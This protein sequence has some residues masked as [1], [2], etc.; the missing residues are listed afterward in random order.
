MATYAIIDPLFK[1]VYV[2]RRFHWDARQSGDDLL[3]EWT[4]SMELWRR[5]TGAR[6]AIKLP[7]LMLGCLW[8]CSF[9]PCRAEPKTL[10]SATHSL[11]SSPSDSSKHSSSLS[12]PAQQTWD[13]ALEKAFS[14]E[15]YRWRK[16]MN[17]QEA[18]A[19][20][21][22]LDKLFFDMRTEIKSLGR[23]LKD[24]MNRLS[25]WLN[26]WFKH[27][28]KSSY[29][30]NP[31]GWGPSLNTWMLIFFAIT[32][33]ALAIFTLRY[34]KNR[35]PRPAL[36]KI[37][38][39]V[40]VDLNDDYIDPLQNNP[41]QWLEMVTQLCEQGQLRLALRACF[42]ACLSSLASE[43][44]IELTTGRGNREALRQLELR[45]SHDKVVLNNFRA[46]LEAFEKTWYGDYSL[47]A[48]DISEHIQ[49]ARSI[50]SKQTIRAEGPA[51]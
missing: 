2:I 20:K 26:D 6:G 51:S 48:M 25:E 41:E 13:S 42:L 36:L 17:E 9:S 44:W 46:L 7:A 10:N 19:P 37:H 12:S 18:E 40:P 38:K 4:Q 22:W 31:K 15:R 33:C 47:T 28:N 39:R 34:I 29:K 16:P 35:D 11:N 45:R 5:R 43:G 24:G 27:Q 1:A 3:V 32:L 14:D 21:G 49:N 8:C 50:H 23:H 30:N